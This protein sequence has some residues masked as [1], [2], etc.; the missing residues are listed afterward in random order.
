[1][2]SADRALRQAYRAAVG[3][4]V[5]PYLLSGVRE[6]WADVRDRYA[7]RPSHLIAAYD[8]LAASLWRAREAR[9]DA[10]PQS[11]GYGPQDWRRP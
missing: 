11:Y 4:G 1:M 5:S 8:R 7:V 9:L 10:A 2:L 3:A 6:Q